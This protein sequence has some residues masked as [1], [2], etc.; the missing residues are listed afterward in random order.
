[1]TPDDMGTDRGTAAPAK[2]RVEHLEELGDEL[3]GRGLRVRLALPDGHGPSL[4][5]TNPDASA[6]TENIVAE[7]DA[8]GWWYRWSWG[9]RLAPAGAVA[10]AAD[11]VQRVLAAHD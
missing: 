4:H 3:A 10:A 6:L 7:E 5:V 1:M 9:E 2:T 11:L 8:D